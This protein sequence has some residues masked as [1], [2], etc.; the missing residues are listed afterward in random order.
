MASIR[1]PDTHSA[2]S[3]APPQWLLVSAVTRIYEGTLPCQMLPR[4]LAGPG[5]EQKCSLCGHTIE[6]GDVGYT[7]EPE[8]DHPL[9]FHLCCYRAWAKGCSLARDP[10]ATS[11]PAVRFGSQKRSGT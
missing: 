7:V 3:A 6:T 5:R 1:A 10:R 9:H 8:R 2:D 4:V 11:G